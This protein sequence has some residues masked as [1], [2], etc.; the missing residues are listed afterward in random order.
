MERKELKKKVD[1]KHCQLERIKKEQEVVN[2][3]LIKLE[4]RWRVLVEEESN[5]VGEILLL[6][7]EQAAAEARQEQAFQRWSST[8]KQWDELYQNN[9]D[10]DGYDL[11]ETGDWMP[12]Y[13]AAEKGYAEIVKLLFTKGADLAAVNKGGRIP[14]M[15]A[16]DKGHID[17]VQLLVENGVNVDVKDKDARTALWYAREARHNAVV[18]LLQRSGATIGNDNAVLTTQ[19][20]RPRPRTSTMEEQQ[21]DIGASIQRIPAPVYDPPPPNGLA[22][23]GEPSNRRVGRRGGR[24]Q[25]TGRNSN[26]DF[27]R[28]LEERTLEEGFMPSSNSQSSWH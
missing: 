2:G 14:L 10:N 20:Q 16:S 15:A 23:L 5:R 3:E 9:F 12:I 21:R 8:R 1:D 26:R 13:W 24:A 22:G 18:Q 4:T 28:I 11:E 17:V 6:S 7:A 27:I 25:Q 19:Q